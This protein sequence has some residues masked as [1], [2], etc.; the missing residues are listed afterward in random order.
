MNLIA[1]LD[2]AARATPDKPF[3]R[4]DGATI[5]YRHMQRRSRRAAEVLAAL[6]IAPGERVAA[7]CFNTPA[8]FD[9]LFGAWR[10][11]AAVV[12]INHKLQ[13]PEVD[14]IL[15]HSASRA[16]L[17]DAALAP[18]LAKVEHGAQRLATEGEANGA[19]PFDR[20]VADAAGIASGTP[21]DTALAEILYTSG[22]TG[23]P[24]GCMHSHRTVALA[25]ATS[26]LAL[27][28]TERE[29]TLT[30]MPI[31][32]ASPLNN[33]FGG[34]LYVGGTVVLMRDYHPLRFLQTVEAEQA[35]L[36]FG[37]PVSYT[38]PLDTI[39]DF[40]SFDL[41]SMRAWLYGGGPIGA[42]LAR[43]LMHAYRSEAFYQVYGMT[44]TGPA[45]T[46]LYPFEQTMK[47][48][49]IGR[50][51]TPGVDVR[52]VTASGGD[53]RPGEIGEILLRADSMMLGY[54]DAPDATRAA[55]ADDGW[56]RSGD[57]AR[58]D[59]DGY[60]FVVDRI[61]DMIV[62]GGENVYSKEVEDVLTAHPAVAEAAVIG[63]AHPEWGETVVA[64]VVLRAAGGT[65]GAEGA[66]DADA[67]RAF[68]ETRLAAYKIPREYVFAERLPR[69]PTG[70]LQKYLL[71]ARGA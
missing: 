70:K 24:K 38:L 53:A 71:R 3:L 33:W 57:V 68:C 32:H 26:A 64:H 4:Y 19:A 62:T 39:A 27:S 46:V 54:L 58:I 52:V 61:K 29:R 11:G 7:M 37:A 50:R 45:G 43:R 28:M 48:G 15:G 2:R 23:R 31:W 56:Y 9:L 13:A 44:E 5:T 59:D 49:S 60:L 25:A 22:T 36:Y 34:T 20:L 35:T 67:L 63:R 8:F 16:V 1:A 14:Y 42:E 40:A 18:V 30:A 55:F 12:P 69:T 65:S 6:G 51:G 17:F 66:V 21:D 41:T 10:I 47:A